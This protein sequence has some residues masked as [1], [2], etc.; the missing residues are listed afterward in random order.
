MIYEHIWFYNKI[1]YALCQTKT[2]VNINKFN[3]LIIIIEKPFRLF[4]L[5]NFRL[6]LITK[7]YFLKTSFQ[8][9]FRYFNRIAISKE[10]S[11][12]IET[13]SNLKK[14]WF[15]VENFLKTDFM[16]SYF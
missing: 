14:K 2:K 11:L 1:M 5:S 10:I 8:Y 4:I 12:G 7:L 13:F 9:V 6:T 16:F 15:C 3:N